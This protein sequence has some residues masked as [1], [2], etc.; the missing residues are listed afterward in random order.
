M[1]THGIRTRGAVVVLALL[2]LGATACGSSSTKST[3]ATQPQTS[4]IAGGSDSANSTP[5]TDSGGATTTTAAAAKKTG[6]V[7]DTLINPDQYVPAD[8]ATVTLVKVIDPATQVEPATLRI[9]ELV[10]SDS[11]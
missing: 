4:T 10:G 7:G 8:V 6:H 3:S 1:N 2:A 9:P 11:R 5:T